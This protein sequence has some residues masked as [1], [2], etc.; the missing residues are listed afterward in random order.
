M[1]VD[2]EFTTKATALLLG[3]QAEYPNLVMLLDST[4]CC[5]N[6]NVMVRENP[7]SWPV[8]LLS[9]NVAVQVYMNPVL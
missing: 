1:T 6:S 4:R 2:V 8:D 5:T 3:M 9:R 7:P